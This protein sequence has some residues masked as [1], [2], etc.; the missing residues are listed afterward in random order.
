MLFGETAV[1]YGRQRGEKRAGTQLNER[2]DYGRVVAYWPD[3]EK[4]EYGELYFPMGPHKA[5]VKTYRLTHPYSTEAEAKEA[6]EA[7]YN[8]V[9]RRDQTLSLTT[10]GNP[11]ITA[12]CKIIIRGLRK[13]ADGSYIVKTATHSFSSGGYQTSIQAYVEP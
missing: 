12:E 3:L 9:N 8:E 11:D 10:I 2:Q 13:D 7:K 1:G 6:T 5:D 4:A